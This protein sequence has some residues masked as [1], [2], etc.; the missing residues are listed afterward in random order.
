MHAVSLLHASLTISTSS[1]LPA[2]MLGSNGKSRIHNM[3]YMFELNQQVSKYMWMQAPL[4][5]IIVLII[6]Y[7]FD[8]NMLY[9]VMRTAKDAHSVT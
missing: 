6:D 3:S 8:C 5:E 4:H 1:L 2:T 7:V 9:K